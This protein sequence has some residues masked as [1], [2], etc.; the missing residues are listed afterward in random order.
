VS[1]FTG[2]ADLTRFALRRDRVRIAVWVIAI[3]V[4]V[5]ITAASTKSLFPTQ[6][7]LDQAAAA[8]QDNPAAL[9][10]NGPAVA[11]NTMGGQIAFQVGAVGLTVVGLMSLLMVGRLTRGEEESGRLELIRSMAVGRHAPLAAAVIVVGAWSRWTSRPPARSCS[12]P[13]TRCSGS[14]SSG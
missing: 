9:A 2:T 10:F 12:A 13:P 11:L 3:V 4:L 7:D 5:I 14:S 8:S 6:A 1:S